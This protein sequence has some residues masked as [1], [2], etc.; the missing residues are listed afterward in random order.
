VTECEGGYVSN[1]KDIISNILDECTTIQIELHDLLSPFQDEYEPWDPFVFEEHST[2]LYN[3]LQESRDQ[4]PP[5]VTV[6]CRRLAHACVEESSHLGRKLVEWEDEGKGNRLPALQ[7][8]RPG[9]AQETDRCLR[10]MED[11][12]NRVT[13]SE[14][15]IDLQYKFPDGIFPSDVTDIVNLTYDEALIVFSK[16]CYTSTIALCGKTIETVLAALYT[17]VTGNDADEERLG[18]DAIASRLKKAGY[19]FKG[20]IKDQLGIIKAHRNKA[21]HGSIIIPTVD[22]ARGVLSLARDVLQKA[23]SHKD[24]S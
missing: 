13:R 1:Y 17:E 10:V 21:V 23:A 4:L 16:G 14:V 2:K 15:V 8:M 9:L 11:E 20:T 24:P 6:A 7:W 19:A 5:P 3:L 18:A 12:Y 22:E